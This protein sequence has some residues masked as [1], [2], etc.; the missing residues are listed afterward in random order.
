MKYVLWP[1]WGVI[2]FIFGIVEIGLFL[3]M[4]V[5]AFLWTF[6]ISHIPNW[7]AYTESNLPFNYGYDKNPI[8]TY[9]RR[10]TFGKYKNEK[11][12]NICED[13]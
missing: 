12:S 8:E 2:V 4:C 5:L 10:L 13:N 1:V 6:N 7:K 9:V 11:D 3:L